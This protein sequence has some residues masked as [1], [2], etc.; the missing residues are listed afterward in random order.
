[1][2]I[3]FFSLTASQEVSEAS[4]GTGGAHDKPLRYGKVPRQAALNRKVFNT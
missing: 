1:M 4:R 2:C 3:N